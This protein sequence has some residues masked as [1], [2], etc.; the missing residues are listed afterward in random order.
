MQVN[1]KLPPLSRPT[2]LLPR[3]PASSPSVRRVPGQPRSAWGR[4]SWGRLAR[5]ST[6]RRSTA[7]E[8]ANFDWVPHGRTAGG[9]GCC[10]TTKAATAFCLTPLHVCFC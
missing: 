2:P 4:Q 9:Q 10:G 6:Y 5:R 1:P 7:T 3:P 8:S